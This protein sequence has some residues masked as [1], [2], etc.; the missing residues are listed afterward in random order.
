MRMTY[1]NNGYL[2]NAISLSHG[3]VGG[4]L[5]REVKWKM[6]WMF[7]RCEERRSSMNME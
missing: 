2:F 5:R 1:N 4:I 7:L 6:G 3:G